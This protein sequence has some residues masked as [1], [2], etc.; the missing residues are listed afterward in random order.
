MLK[1][2]INVFYSEDDKGFIADVPDLQYCSAFGETQ[3]EAM[4][5]IMI[6]MELWLEVAKADGDDIPEPKYKPAIYQI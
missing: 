2:H 4:R 5:E 6:A 1:Y 3:E